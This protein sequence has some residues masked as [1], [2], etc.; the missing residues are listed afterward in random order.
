M[1]ISDIKRR[2]VETIERARRQAAGRRT[3]H[4]E[5]ARE[6]EAFLDRAAIPVF[7]QVSNVLRAEGFAFTVFTPGGSVRLMSDRSTEDYIELVLDTSGDEPLVSGHTGRSRGRRVVE[8]ERP[9]G[10]PAALTEND[11]LS[12]VL[13]ALEPLVER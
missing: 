9:L 7:K 13:K 12:F 1:E 4:D 8:S 10:P 11:V 5:A 3:R 2:V 6:Y